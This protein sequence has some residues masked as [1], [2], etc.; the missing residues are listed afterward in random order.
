MLRHIFVHI[1]FET[2]KTNTGFYVYTGSEFQ[3]DAPERER[4]RQ[5]DRD[6]ER[7][8]HAVLFSV[9][10]IPFSRRDVQLVLTFEREE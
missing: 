2:R 9:V 1:T 7:F 3:R 4:E 8:T 6:R 10:V 5:T